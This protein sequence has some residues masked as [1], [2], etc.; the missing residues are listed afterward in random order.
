IAIQPYKLPNSCRFRMLNSAQRFPGPRGRSISGNF[1]LRSVEFLSWRGSNVVRTPVHG[2]MDGA[3][4]YSDLQ[5]SDGSWERGVRR[6]RAWPAD[7]HRATLPLDAFSSL[8][9]RTSRVHE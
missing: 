7:L 4:I 3:R 6:H 2:E 1:P 9:R 5:G 8:A